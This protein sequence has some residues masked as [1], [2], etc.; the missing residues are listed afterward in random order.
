MRYDILIP[1]IGGLSLFIYGMNMMGD[2]LQ[3]AAG[4]RI[5]KYI[6]M[7]TKNRLMAVLVGCLVTMIIQ[8][9]SAT[10]V[11]VVGF[12]NAGVMNLSQAVGIIIGANLGTTITGQLIA[13][14]MD[15]IAPIIAA[16]GVILQ[17]ISKKQKTKDLSEVLVG[18]G[19]LFIGIN[20]MSNGLKPLSDMQW[21]K[22]LVLKL[23]NPYIGVLVGIALTTVVQSSS[24]AV[25]LL[26][27]L[28]KD[29]LIGLGHAFPILFGTNIGTTTTALISSLGANENAKRAAFI[30]FLFNFIGTVI[31]MLFL[32]TPLEKFIIRVTPFGADRQIANA[33][34]LFNLVN[35]IIQLPF[36]N[37]LVKGA[38]FFVRG[39]DKKEQTKSRYLDNR[40]IETPAIAILQAKKE[41]LR[42]G[43]T[44][45]ENF[46]S[47]VDAFYT[48]NTLETDKIYEKEYM[49]NRIEREII[50]YLVKLSS[51]NISEEEK[52]Q[53][54]IMM[55]T[56]HDFERI[57]DHTKNIAELIDQS[58]EEN[59]EFTDIAKSEFKKISNEIKRAIQCAIES[60]GTK[61]VN[62]AMEA[63]EIESRVDGYE[64]KFRH[65]HIRRIND[66]I[67]NTSAGVIFLDMLSNM[68]RISDHSESIA[69]YVIH[70]DLE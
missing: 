58:I 70:R 66:G 52:Q 56:V 23:N 19:I 9:S 39:E 15:A 28:A 7:F 42:M 51:K 6:E 53:I 40:I 67:C 4:K 43:E 33:H 27:T 20:M 60:Y 45:F 41:V 49:I 29:G 36:A 57:G 8:S 61:D 24:A 14:R 31:F 21:F 47:A 16:I 26:Q 5:R 44:A 63:L 17:T 55:D 35:I 68:E 2:S 64:K 10:T 1:A 62:L 34:T 30:H 25:G 59:L 54:F 22:D 18:F 46:V 38:N 3:K 48:K 12:V 32:R 37:L 11:M 50:N 13:L 65:N 69:N